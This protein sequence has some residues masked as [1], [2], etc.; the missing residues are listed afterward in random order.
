MFIGVPVVPV[1]VAIWLRFDGELPRK[2]RYQLTGSPPLAAAFQVRPS[3][4]AEVGVAARPVG[5]DGPQGGERNRG[6]YR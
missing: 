1:T 6:C 3:L 5:A 2:T 4:V